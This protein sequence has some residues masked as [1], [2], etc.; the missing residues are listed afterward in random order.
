MGKPI[1]YSSVPISRTGVSQGLQSRVGE[2]VICLTLRSVIIPAKLHF[3]CMYT[4]VK[5][6]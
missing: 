2:R 3:P 6:M 1:L 5:K 4:V